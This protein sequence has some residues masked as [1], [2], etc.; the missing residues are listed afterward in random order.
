MSIWATIQNDIKTAMRAG[1]EG[2]L[3][4]Q[5]L[6]MLKSDLLLICKESTTQTDAPTDEQCIKTCRKMI[7]QRQESAKQFLAA[8]DSD[9]AESEQKEI[10]ILSVYMPAPL[11]DN[12][13]S[14]IITAA[15]EDIQPTGMKDMGK[16]MAHITKATA[17]R[18]DIAQISQ[19]VKAKLST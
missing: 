15:F 14:D 9:R 19:T 10:K 12:E 7:K 16:I 11:N 4:L 8:N 13:I 17:G 2:K 3:Q 5:T 1:A 6:R 18:A